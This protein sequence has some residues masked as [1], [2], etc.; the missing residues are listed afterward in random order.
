MANIVLHNSA[1][2]VIRAAKYEVITNGSALASRRPGN[3]LWPRTPD[4]DLNTVVRDPQAWKNLTTEKKQA[5]K[6][7]LT[8]S[9]TTSSTDLSFPTL[10]RSLDR[11]HASNGW[12]VTKSLY[13]LCLSG[14]FSTP[15]YV[16]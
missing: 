10:S 1:G 14:C 4:G 7:S 6:D 8:L 11:N 16:V 9:W 15:P 5:F 3:N 12:G 2:A 13:T